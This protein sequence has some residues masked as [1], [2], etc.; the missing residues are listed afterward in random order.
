MIEQLCRPLIAVGELHG[1]MRIDTVA[2]FKGMF[3]KSP[4]PTSLKE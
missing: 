3:K 4:D 2:F 1:I